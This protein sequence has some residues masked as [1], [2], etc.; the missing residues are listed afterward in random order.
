MAAPTLKKYI[1]ALLAPTKLAIGSALAQLLAMINQINIETGVSNIPTNTI[2]GNSSGASGPSTPLVV[3]NMLVAQSGTLAVNFGG[4]LSIENAGSTASYTVTPGNGLGG[5]VWIDQWGAILRAW[6]HNQN[7][8]MA[9][10]TIAGAGFGIGASG[11]SGTGWSLSSAGIGG[12]A[13]ANIANFQPVVFSGLTGLVLVD[14]WGAI[15]AVF[16]V[17]GGEMIQAPATIPTTYS[18]QEI[19]NRDVLNLIN[20]GVVSR[21]TDLYAQRPVFGYNHM[22]WAG[23][24]EA[25]GWQGI[26]IPLAQ[27]YDNL[28]LGGATRSLSNSSWISVGGTNTLEPL[29]AVNSATIRTGAITNLGSVT[30][31][32]SSSTAGT[33]AQTGTTAFSSVFQVGDILQG[34][35]F[36]TT[37][38]ANNSG[39]AGHINQ[40]F[41]VASVG[42]TSL[43]YTN[44]ADF[45]PVAVAGQ[46]GVE[47]QIVQTQIYGEDIAIEGTNLYRRLMLANQHLAADPTRLLVSTNTAVSGTA[48]ASFRHQATVNTVVINIKNSGTVDTIPTIGA[49]TAGISITSITN[50]STIYNQGTDYALGAGATI[51]WLGVN[52]PTTGASYTMTFSYTSPGFF[53]QNTGAATAIKNLGSI[54]SK[55]TGLS[56]VHMWQG[57]TDADPGIIGAAT[58]YAAYKTNLSGWMSDVVTAV[59]AGIYGQTTLPLILVT[60][61]SGYNVTDVGYPLTISQAQLDLCLTPPYSTVYMVGPAYAPP[62]EGIHFTGNGYRWWGAMIAKVL[63]RILERG[64]QWLP[65][66]MTGA[67]YRGNTILANFHVPYPPLQFQDVFAV[68]TPTLFTDKGFTVLDG[69]G[70]RLPITAV[71]L[72]GESMVAITVTGTITAGSTVRYADGTFHNGQGNLCD[73]DPTFSDVTYQYSATSGQLPAENIPAWIG[74]PYPLWN[75]CCIG[76]VPLVAN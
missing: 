10:T 8:I 31:T 73:S 17:A 55:T 11:V 19:E 40:S 27:P 16:D 66:Y 23:Q 14:Q 52:A 34:S 64:E 12:A 42:T 60:Q 69:S 7:L 76:S 41:T 72:V 22:L 45:V 74:Q 67:T 25:A 24:S 46:T 33:I 71:T 35:G 4:S 1:E 39:N 70:T 61:L 51:D 59:A 49:G 2:L 53:S 44:T 54:A 38:V 28:M 32:I 3:G 15:L 18:A 6:D 68:L 58:T 57:G 37:A 36:T 75:W 63:N 62:R 9:G 43:T 29:I 5:E 21:E 26:A 47:L 56:V 30:I 50:G 20:S 48:I 13:S 65:L